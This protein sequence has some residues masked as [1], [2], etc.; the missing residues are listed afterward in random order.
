MLAASF[1]RLQSDGDFERDA[2]GYIPVV[3][4][5]CDS[6]PCRERAPAMFWS[7]MTWLVSSDFI[8]LPM[9]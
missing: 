1:L 6:R 8:M 7:Q 5:Q 2:F 4:T 9:C 3:S